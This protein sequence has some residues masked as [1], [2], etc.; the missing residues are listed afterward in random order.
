MTSITFPAPLPA[1]SP[2][3]FPPSSTQTYTTQIIDTSTHLCWDAIL[4]LPGSQ[5]QL[6][7]CNPNT[8]TQLF[9]A[10]AVS[11][12]GYVFTVVQSEKDVQQQE[13][14]CVE[15]GEDLNL[16][17]GLCRDTYAFQ[18][19]NVQ[20]SGSS[21]PWT[22]NGISVGGACVVP[23]QQQATL[24]RTV[25]TAQQQKEPCTT[26]S[27]GIIEFKQTLSTQQPL[28]AF[29]RVQVLPM[30]IDNLCLDASNPASGSTQV[31]AL[32]CDPKRASQQW[33]FYMGRI[34]N[35]QSGLCMFARMVNMYEM[36]TEREEV[37]LMECVPPLG[38]NMLVS[39]SLLWIRSEEGVV[40]NGQSGECV[41]VVEGRV[42]TGTDV[43]RGN[44]VLAMYPKTFTSLTPTHFQ[45]PLPSS[46]TCSPQQPVLRKDIRDL[47][48][49]ELT[50]FF[51]A[52]TTL[53]RTPSPLGFP[54]SYHDL[55]AVHSLVSNLIHSQP[56]FLPFHRAFLSTFETLLQEASGNSSMAVPY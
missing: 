45:M 5:L 54:S 22:F 28:P 26:S 31:L 48:Q 14:H 40:Y 10:H 53:R 25:L 3:T 37:G 42:Y 30:Q 39:K 13:Q 29:P 41:R 1:I 15:L 21:T 12:V 50:A 43:C 6:K 32:P 27:N 34:R 55:V 56:V 38:A 8:S 52:V 23:S 11:A 44:D 7:P 36:A 17:V 49:A 47:T 24:G 4:P 20:V 51:N 19:F 18:K 46:K 9:K 2:W 33:F 35:V 16:Q